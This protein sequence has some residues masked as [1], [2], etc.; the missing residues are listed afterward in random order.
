MLTSLQL[1]LFLDQARSQESSSVFCFLT[2]FFSRVPC[3]YSTLTFCPLH[4]QNNSQMN[5]NCSSLLAHECSYLFFSINPFLPQISREI[6]SPL[7]PLYSD[8]YWVLN[9]AS[10][11]NSFIFR[12]ISLV[13]M[14]A[15]HLI[16]KSSWTETKR[17]EG[18][19]SLPITLFSQGHLPSSHICSLPNYLCLL[20][21]VHVPKIS[22]IVTGNQDL[23][24]SRGSLGEGIGNMRQKMN[25]GILEYSFFLK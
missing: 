17:L 5:L 8:R 23:M 21:C 2:D 14:L 25:T 13:L 12:P 19:F 22:E 6:L 7:T 1:L 9:S 15:D 4:G 11:V 18:G 20:I 16:C 10:F 3:F 24:Y